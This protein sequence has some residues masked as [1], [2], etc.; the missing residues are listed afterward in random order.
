MV[1]GSWDEDDEMRVRAEEA[2]R[3]Y[4]RFASKIVSEQAEA[5]FL[6][7]NIIDAFF[8]CLLV[9]MIEQ[10]EGESRQS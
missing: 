3:S 5:Q 9:R 7:G 4:G 6:A 8:D 2:L 1:Q 10:I